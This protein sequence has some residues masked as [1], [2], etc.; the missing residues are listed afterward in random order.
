MTN[1]VKKKD[2][3]VSLPPLQYKLV[4]MIT[5]V[6]PSPNCGHYTAIGEAGNGQFFQFDDSSVRPVSINQ[7]MNT[8]SYVCFY[9]M[10]RPTKQA[11]INKEDAT[12][13]KVPAA[14]PKPSQS[15]KPCTVTSNGAGPSPIRP[16]IIPA[17]GN[18]TTKSTPNGANKLGV[19]AA[20]K[21]HTNK[22]KQNGLVPYDDDDDSDEEQAPSRPAPNPLTN[23]HKP[24]TSPFVPR[25]VAMN[26][27]KR[28]QEPRP[29]S[30]AA[31]LAPA[32]PKQP[33]AGGKLETSG[34][35]AWRV[36]ESE[37]HDP[38]VNSDNSTGSTSGSWKVTSVAS[39]S[40]S[41]SRSLTPAQ[42]NDSKPATPVPAAQE[43]TNSWRPIAN[44]NSVTSSSTAS[45]SSVGSTPEH[46][47]SKRSSSIEE[48]EADLDRGRTKKVKSRHGHEENNGRPAFNSQNSN[49]FQSFQNRGHN[50]N[51][52][53]RWSHNNSHRSQGYDNKRDNFRSRSFSNDRYRQRDDNDFRDKHKRRNSYY[54]DRGNGHGGFRNGGGGHRDYDNRSYNRR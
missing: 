53:N 42:S 5:H 1:Y 33:E 12:P 37:H 45:S 44:Q 52:N 22:A 13:R 6:G 3:S 9:E 18:G 43:D 14:G 24:K 50:Q 39:A 34:S 21:P 26:A 2:V 25:S 17:N 54:D 7:A 23:G 36:T 16:R 15:Q 48:Y 30:P 11:W 51:G 38:S 46:R 29:D 4:S 20:P 40:T 35:G 47:A 8:A 28:S 31:I 10:T 41:S 19:V 49:P 32:G 27:L